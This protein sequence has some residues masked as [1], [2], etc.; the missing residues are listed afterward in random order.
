[1]AA[2]LGEGVLIYGV[3]APDAGDTGRPV[4]HG[5]QYLM[6]GLILVVLIGTAFLT[7]KNARRLLRSSK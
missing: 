7:F 1:V 5:V 6:A 4:V 3:T 2:T